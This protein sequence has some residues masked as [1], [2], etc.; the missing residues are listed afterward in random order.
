MKLSQN[1]NKEKNFFKNKNIVITGASG[2]IGKNLLKYLSQY[3]CNIIAIYNKTKINSK[4]KN[5]VSIKHDLLQSLPENLLKDKIDILFH[6]A[7]PKA[8]RKSMQDNFE[9]NNGLVIDKNIIKYSIKKKISL[10]F[11]AS[12]AGVYKISK[13]NFKEK[14]IPITT[15]CDGIYGKNKLIAEKMLFNAFDK[16]N[17][18]ICRFFSI[19]G[20]SSNTIINK[21]KNE[22]RKNKNIS[23]WGDG[24]TIRSWLHID[25][26]IRGIIKMIIYKKNDVFYNLGSSEKLSLYK[27]FCLIKS[28]F[29]HSK[30]SIIYSKILATGPK[31]RFTNSH[32]LKKIGWVQKIKL[33]KGLTII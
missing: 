18:I 17:L 27:I 31:K 28:K 10:F 19:Y 26:T 15:N 20:K 13:T 30:S 33:N 11:Y 9:I 2:F 32:N 22:V 23:I 21:W 3:Q 6:F 7:G 25:D 4:K 8:D 14:K 24:K 5:I 12:S 1:L 16:K 29:K